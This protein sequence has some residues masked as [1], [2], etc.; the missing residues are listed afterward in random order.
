VEQARPGNAPGIGAIGERDD[1]RTIVPEREPSVSIL[2][3]IR[4]KIH[5]V[6]WEMNSEY[7]VPTAHRS[8]V[9]YYAAVKPRETQ[10]GIG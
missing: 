9:I 6:S 4:D 5:A 8:R 3:V 10:T 2:A 1:S 7:F